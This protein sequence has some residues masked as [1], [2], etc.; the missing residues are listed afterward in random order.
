MHTMDWCLEEYLQALAEYGGLTVEHD[1]KTVYVLSV[2]MDEHGAVFSI[3][4]G[5]AAGVSADNLG[6]AVCVAT[7]N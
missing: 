5:Y 7:E 2:P 1:G 3:P 6:R 4:Q